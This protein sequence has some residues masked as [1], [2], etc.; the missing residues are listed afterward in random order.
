MG[1]DFA[2][3]LGWI[4]CAVAFF[5]YMGVRSWFEA[6]RRERE[7][8][9]R[10][11]AIKKVA[12]MQGTA[13]EPILELLREALK[14]PP[15]APSPAWIGP[16]QARAFY[17]SETLKRIAE[18]KGSD[19]DAVLAVMRED[20][21]QSARRVRAGL[22]LAGLIVAAA[23]VGLSVFLWAFVPDRPV[24]FAGLIPLLVGVVLLAFA[25]I[26]APRD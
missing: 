24:F 5:S 10:T 6:Q 20:E 14:P 25:F 23:G 19:A 11:E 13:S 2:V 8:F 7:A 18:L 9:Y 4:G 21:R 3:A 17:K 15:H 22:Q 26:S 1:E 16:V 12:E